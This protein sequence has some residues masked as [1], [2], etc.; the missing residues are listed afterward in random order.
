MSTAIRCIYPLAVVLDT[1]GRRVENMLDEFG[2]HSKGM[3]MKITIVAL[4][5]GKYG[6]T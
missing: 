5:V 1:Y 6:R 2:S 3:K 4:M